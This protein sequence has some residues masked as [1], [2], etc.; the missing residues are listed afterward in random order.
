MV[1]NGCC[2]FSWLHL[3]ALVA[4]LVAVGIWLVKHDVSMSSVVSVSTLSFYGFSL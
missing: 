2:S 4:L 1:V 3:G